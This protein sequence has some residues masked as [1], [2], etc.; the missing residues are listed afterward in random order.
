MFF[1]H[2]SFCL[3]LII[4]KKI[5]V[6]FA[7]FYVLVI[8]SISLIINLNL[9]F[10]FAILYFS[11]ITLIYFPFSTCSNNNFKLLLCLWFYVHIVDFSFSALEFFPNSYFP[12]SFAFTHNSF[13]VRLFVDHCCFY[14]LLVN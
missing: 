4:Y 5:L 7:R 11:L 3:F 9:S 10:F 12:A 1:F 6:N 2:T 8:D 14:P 13:N